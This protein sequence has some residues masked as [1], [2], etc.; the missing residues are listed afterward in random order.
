MGSLEGARMLVVGASS[1]IGR[2]T[3]VAAVRGGAHVALVARRGALLAEAVEEAGGG[4]AITANVCVPSDC[5]RLV[6]EAVASLGGLDIVLYATGTA[7]L[8]RMAEVDERDWRAVYETNVVGASNVIR[9]ALAAGIGDGA[10]VSALSSESVPAPRPGLVPYAASKAALETMMT[11]FRAEHPRVRFGVITVGSTLQTDF[12]RDFD[13]VLLGELFADWMRL[14]MLQEGFMNATEL[15][16]AIA[17]IF[18]AV[19]PHPSIGLEHVVLRPPFPVVAS[20]VEA[21]VAAEENQPR[22]AR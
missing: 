19:W 14:G 16:E 3:A 10:I 18:G 13:P 22:G 7:P 4:H 1:G 15:G 20:T 9:A 12:G 6:A 8:R 2:A 11:G 5:T 17:G 21:R